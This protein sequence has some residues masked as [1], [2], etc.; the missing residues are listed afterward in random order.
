M[1]GFLNTT[2]LFGLAGIAIPILIHL[3][4]RQKIRRIEFSTILFLKMIHSQRLRRIRIRQIILLI[5]RALAVCLIVL[6]FARPTIKTESNIGKSQ[7]RSSVALVFDCS[8]S[9]GREDVYYRAKNRAASVLDFLQEGDEAS[10]ILTSS[11]EEVPP[12][13]H[14][15]GYNFK[16]K[17]MKEEVSWSRGDIVESINKAKTLLSESH[18]L[19]KEIYLVSDLQASGFGNDSINLKESLKEKL[20]IL[21]VLGE[22]DNVGLIG[23]GV[24]N[25]ILQSHSPVRV[26]AEVKNFGEKKVEG[27][28]VRI[29]LEK[30]AVAQKI[31]DLEAGEKQRMVFQLMPRKEGWISGMIQIEEDLL[32]QDNQWFFVCYI[33]E[34]N[35]VLLC[36]KSAEDLRSLQLA[37]TPEKESKN[38]FDIQKA[39]HNENWIET[40]DKADVIVFSNYPSFTPNEISKLTNNLEQGTGICFLMGDDVDLKHYNDH[41]FSP[42]FDIYFGNIFEG[43]REDRS[44]LSFGSID[45]GHYLFHGVFEKGEEKIHSPKIYRTIQIMGNVTDKIINLVDGTP[46]LF[47]RRY[48]RG[49]VIFINCGV[50]KHWSDFEY[51]TFFAPLI[52]RIAAYLSNPITGKTEGSVVGSSISMVA[53]IKDLQADCRI[54]TPAKESMFILPDI[55]KNDMVLNLAKAYIPG[56]YQ[57]YYDQTL[58]GMRAVNIDPQESNLQIISKNNLT[59]QFPKAKLNMIQ[60]EE[61]LKTQITMARLGRELWKELLIVGFLILLAEMIIG[62]AWKKV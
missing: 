13:F 34:Q 30:E 27:L 46:F 38:K 49:K 22:S 42:V 44:Y 40:A 50:D 53:D 19:N 59:K 16:K 57:F 45:F 10:L 62:R 8:L 14:H 29:F 36:G 6:A 5:L 18:N 17:L 41:F 60:E 15:K 51:S 33:P 31:I 11:S 1:L 3:F 9:M 21:P 47:E 12:Q 37:L 24:E 4:A 2:L 61:E 55:N 56:I 7:A 52:N 28:L 35:R 20:F 32:P 48:N 26:F 58:L 39:Y 23:G 25:Q 43:K 54:E